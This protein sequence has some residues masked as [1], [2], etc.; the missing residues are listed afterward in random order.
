MSLT[1]QSCGKENL[2]SALFCAD[3]GLPMADSD[4]ADSLIGREILGT[5]QLQELLGKGGMSVVYL[6]RHVLTEQEV[7]VK[8]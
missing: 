2:A 4:A 6:A 3:C 1:C 8:V 5:Y 7:A